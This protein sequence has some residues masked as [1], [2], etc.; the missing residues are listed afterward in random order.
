MFK[1]KT[2]RNLVMETIN[3]KID[4]AQEEYEAEC[5]RLHSGFQAEISSLE[6]KLD[7][8]KNNAASNLVSKIISG[9]F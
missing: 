4:K 5:A 2:I 8:D 6:E 9:A 1:D 3:L 7:V